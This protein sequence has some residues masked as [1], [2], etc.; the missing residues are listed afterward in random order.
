MIKEPIYQQRG[1]YVWAWPCWWFPIVSFSASW[2]FSNI[3]IYSEFIEIRT[4]F[5]NV[6]YRRED[7]FVERWTIIPILFDGISLNKTNSGV[8]R[9]FSTFRA[10]KLL[11]ELRK[12]GY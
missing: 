5:F 4:L 12:A 7:I 10:R 2:P 1:G 11:Y 6:R 8:F 9:L 3:K